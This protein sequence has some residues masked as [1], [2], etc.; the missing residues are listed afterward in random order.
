MKFLSS[1][2]T[3]LLV[4]VAVFIL[5]SSAPALAC[6]ACVGDISGSK[7]TVAA[8]WGIFAMVVIMFAMLGTLIGCGFYLRYRAEHPLPDYNE[9]LTET[10][11]Q[12]KPGTNPL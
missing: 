1:R 7:Q 8:A 3:I 10:D 9:M 6:A 12:P 2:T 11:G 5:N 4:L